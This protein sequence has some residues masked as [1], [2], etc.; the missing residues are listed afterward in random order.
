MEILLEAVG[1]ER[2]PFWVEDRR[3]RPGRSRHPGALGL[4]SPDTEPIAD[5]L[6]K[7]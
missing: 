7:L 6:P 4:F 3:D 5:A 1:R 2:L